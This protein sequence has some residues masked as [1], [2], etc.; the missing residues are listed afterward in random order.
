MMIDPNM[1]SATMKMPNAQPRESCL[2][3]DGIAV[4][5]E[6]GGHFHWITMASS[7][8]TIPLHGKASRRGPS[9]AQ[10]ACGS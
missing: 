1:I 10:I 9:T 3:D 8:G 6:G 7:L 4:D 5:I 2:F